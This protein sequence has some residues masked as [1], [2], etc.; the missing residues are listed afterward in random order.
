[1]TRTTALAG[2][3]TECEEKEKMM[4]ILVIDDTPRHLTS[5]LQLFIDHEIETCSS[6]DEALEL[7]EKKFVDP[8][9]ES[10]YSFNDG[11]KE[12]PYWDI[13]LCDLLMPAGRDNQGGRGNEFVGQ[14][15]PVGW[16]LALV[17]ATRG[18]KYVAVVTDMNHHEHPASAMLDRIPP[19][20][21]NGAKVIF[22]NSIGSVGIMGT[23]CVCP[24]CNG[25]LKRKS[26]FDGKLYE[27]SCKTGTSFEQWGKNWQGILDELLREK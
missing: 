6:Y 26:T 21:I 23:E 2:T 11:A 22:T 20:S 25:T 10:C 9:G 4:R 17:A 13:V 27:C 14:E 3:I 24:D 15:M 16:S 8:S 7:L 5:A 18:A 1:M 19:M 12:L